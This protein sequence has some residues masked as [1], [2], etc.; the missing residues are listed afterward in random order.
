VT[1]QGKVYPIARNRLST[2]ELAGV[3]F[4]PDGSTLLVNIQHDHL[5][6]AIQGPWRS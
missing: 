5:T 3:T 6:V 4:T 1:P 2:S